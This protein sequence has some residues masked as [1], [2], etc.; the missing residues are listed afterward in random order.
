MNSEY[1][2]YLLRLQRNP[3]AAHWRATLEN[4]HTGEAMHF[5]TEELLLR[6]LWQVVGDGCLQLQS[7]AGLEGAASDKKQPARSDEQNQ[8]EERQ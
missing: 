1:Q 4:V 3:T 6:Y 8:R 7:D 2:A 5:A